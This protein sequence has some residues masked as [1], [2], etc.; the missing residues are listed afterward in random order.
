[1]SLSSLAGKLTGTPSSYT[2]T[3]SAAPF[4]I[5]ATLRAVALQ[6]YFTQLANP[7]APKSVTTARYT[8]SVVRAVSGDQVRRKVIDETKCLSCHETLSLHGGNCVNDIG[9]CV[10]CHNPNL[11]SSG[12]TADATKTAQDQKDAHPVS[13][14][15]PPATTPTMR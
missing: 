10:I 13:G 1:M 2:A 3:L 8:T 14:K 9:V 5:A 4:P 7:G 11:S 15:L 12:K 6:G